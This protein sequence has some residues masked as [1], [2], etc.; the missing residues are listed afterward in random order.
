ML[1]NFL[2]IDFETEKKS[3][4]LKNLTEVIK[5][6]NQLYFINLDYIPTKKIAEESAKSFEESQVNLKNIRDNLAN[7]RK[8][9]QEKEDEKNSLEKKIEELTKQLDRCQTRLNNSTELLKSLENEKKEWFKKKEELKDNV[10]NIIGDI[11]I[12]SGII[13]YLGAFTKSYRE[14]IIE[15]WSKLIKEANIPITQSE[16]P[17]VI[18][19][20]ILGDKMEIENWKMKKLPNDSFSVDNALIIYK[21]SRW[22]LLIDPQAQAVEWITETYNI[23]DRDYDYN[24]KK[25]TQVELP[26][27]VI[28]PTMDQREIIKKTTICLKNG[29]TLLYENVSETLLSVLAPVYKKEYTKEGSIFY[30]NL[31]KNKTEVDPNFRMFI[32]TKLPKPHYLPEICVS[33]TLV[34]FTVTEEGMEDQMLNFVVEKEDYQTEKLRKECIEIVNSF[35]KKRREIELHILELLHNGSKNDD[36][37]N[38]ILDNVEL[39]RTLSTSKEKSKEMEIQLI[40]QADSEEIIKKKRQIYRNVSIHVAHLFFT[41]SD[42]SNIEPVYQYSLNWFKDIFNLSILFTQNQVITDKSKRL[43]ILK[44][45]FTSLL[46]DKV[47]MSLFEKDKI[48]FSFLLNMKL[49][50]ISYSPEIQAIYSKENRFLVIGGSGKEFHKPNPAKSDGRDDIWLSHVAWN[51]LIELSLLSEKYSK[52][53]DSFNSNYQEWKKVM[54]SSDPINEV[55]PEPFG[56]F[57]LFEKLIIM[58]IVRPDKTIPAL[59]NLICLSLGNSKYI[60][61]PP[62]DVQ[63]AY[64][65]SKNTTPIFFILSPGADPIVI[66]ESL[67]KKV[68]RNWLD[69][70]KSLSLGQGQEEA[71]RTNIDIGIKNNKWIILQNCHLARSFMDEL[72]KLVDSIVFD[73]NSTFRLFLTG[74]PSKVIPISIIQNSIKL[75]NEPPRGLRQSVLRSYGTFDDRF[76]DS[77]KLGYTFKRFVYN[78]CFFHALILERRK[79][80]PLGWNIPYEF[81]GGDLSISRSQLFVFLENYDDIQWDALNYMIAEANYG[82]RVTDPADRRL[83]NIIFRNL[84][85]PEILKLDFKIFGLKD[86]EIPVD[87]MYE[88]HL[89][90]ISTIPDIDVPAVFG[91]HDNAD[92]T[93]AINETNSVFENILLTLPRA[94]NLFFIFFHKNFF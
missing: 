57:P 88:E 8:I 17:F 54:D 71:A 26:F 1:C 82:G 36:K 70:V 47:C 91:L 49:K 62:F 19:Q 24:K 9:K 13:A 14:E 81:S 42:L 79:Y 38:T 51:S 73:E 32:A 22:P 39:I 15:T 80:G 31:N 76:Y 46:Y 29:F 10:K 4:A 78:L 74:M 16:S 75:T 23:K 59:K 65:E 53:V 7:T 83:I 21:S 5:D 44:E 41:V 72:E 50:M 3:A 67:A 93:C 40:K 11:L 2:Q 45:N 48:V 85:N 18:M 68:N 77:C 63:K 27:H 87:G 55:Y 60:T 58:R 61:S 34:N 33:L 43:D 20:R 35:T 64:Q 25:G 89:N 90:L 86:Y 69:D 6:Y 30:V 56:T 66:I 37:D 92:I 28:K 94:G 84:C 52:L 12:S